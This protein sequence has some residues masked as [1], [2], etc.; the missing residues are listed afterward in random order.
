MH[1]PNEIKILGKMITVSQNHPSELNGAGN[2]DSEWYR[3]RLKWIN[4]PHFPADKIAEAFLHEIIEALDDF[5]D[6]EIPH[7]TL[8]ILSEG[9]FQVIKDNQLNFN[10]SVKLKSYKN[11]VGSTT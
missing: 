6:L 2:W 8:S 7:K 4:D 10:D 1:I 5:C 11:P 3:I 9:L